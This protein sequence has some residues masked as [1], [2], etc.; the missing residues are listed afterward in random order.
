VASDVGEAAA[1][2]GICVVAIAV[3]MRGTHI[4]IPAIVL[5]N[6]HIAAALAVGIGATVDVSEAAAGLGICAIAIGAT[7][8][9]GE[10]A[11]RSVGGF[12]W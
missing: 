8:G 7:G 6:V 4:D 1:Q 2:Q 9:V 10:A 12:C 11:A 5:A 3:V